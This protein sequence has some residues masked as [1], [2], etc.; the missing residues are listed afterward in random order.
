M[1]HKS[2]EK[3]AYEGSGLSLQTPLYRHEVEMLLIKW[4][5]LEMKDFKNGFDDLKKAQEKVYKMVGK[6]DFSDFNEWI[7]SEDSY[8][9]SNTLLD[10]K[11]IV[12]N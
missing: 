8:T 11:M 6:P 12:Q 5:F 2:D 4:M 7:I 9:K 3:D 1:V 10:A